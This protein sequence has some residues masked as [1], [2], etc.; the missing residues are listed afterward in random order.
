MFKQ[1]SET[2]ITTSKI[3]LYGMLMGLTVIATMLISI[4]MIATQGYINLGDAMVLL[5]GTILGPLGGFIVGGLGSALADILLGYA[6]YAPFTLF[7]KGLEGAAGV[8]LF[9]KL[10][11]EKHL[12]ISMVIGGLL[13]ATGYLVVEIFLYGYPAAIASFPGNIFQG[14]VGAILATL[15][16]K[17]IINKI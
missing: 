11:K 7:I 12:F 8:F 3:A 15:L 4:P 10:F 16:Y 9:K 1:N 14:Q 2:R 13:M 5:S 17:N 6:Y